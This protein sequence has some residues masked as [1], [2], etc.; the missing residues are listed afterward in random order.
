MNTQYRKNL[1][2][3]AQA[4]KDYT[5]KTKEDIL[6][7]VGEY[8]ITTSDDNTTASTKTVPSGATRVKIKKIY[9]N[10]LKYNPSVASDTTVAFMKTLPDTVYTL[11][12]SY[13]YGNSEVSEN[14]LVLQDVVETTYNGITYKVKDGVVTLNGTCDNDNTFL[15][16]VISNYVIKAGT[17]YQYALFNNM[18]NTSIL[19][20]RLCYGVTTVEEVTDANITSENVVK[21]FTRSVSQ[22]ITRL[23]I[24][25]N[26]S[27]TFNNFIFKPMLIISST[28]PTTFVKGYDGIHNLELTGLRIDGANILNVPNIAE[29]TQD[30]ITFSVTNGELK[31]K[32]TTSVNYWTYYIQLSTPISVGT[33]LCNNYYS[34]TTASTILYFKDVSYGNDYID[35]AYAGSTNRT[36][37]IT[38]TVNYIRIYIHNSGTA[39]DFASKLLI[40]KN[41]TAPT[42][43]QPYIAPTTKTID[44]STILYNG[45]P[46]FEGNSLKAVNDV[47]DIL[48]PYKATKKLGS[49]TFTGNETITQTT[50]QSGNYR[51]LILLSNSKAPLNADT[52]PNIIFSD[53]NYSVK[54]ANQIYLGNAGVGIASTGGFIFYDSSIQ[55]ETDFK[56]YITGKTINYE[57]ATPIEVSID[58]SSTLRGI[59][60]Y[61]KGTITLQNTY[62]MD[63][64]NTI[65]YN[66]MIKENCCSKIVQTRGGNVVKT[67][68]LPTQA[69]DGY[70]AGS[71]S[72]VRDFTTNKRGTNVSKNSSLGSLNYTYDSTIYKRFYVALSNAKPVATNNDV[73]NA[74]CRVYETKSVQSIFDDLT[75]DMEMGIS[76]NTTLTIR[77]LSYDDVNTFKTAMTNEPLYYE[78]AD[79]SKTET[80]IDAVENVIEVEPNDVL[81]FYNSDDELVTIPSD[82]TYRIEVA[83]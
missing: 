26:S 42:T 44:L 45:S 2:A 19:G 23:V 53:T 51:Y 59:Q 47:K 67:I 21:S 36:M 31:M 37:N 5:D 62:N 75:K 46:L 76:N 78:L 60:G 20:I 82:L 61:S 35:F 55:T 24:R 70:S 48:T 17:T 58:W 14:L 39:V 22:E 52:T 71:V 10:T 80:D 83:R 68:N 34:G 40:T 32:G 11:D 74:L 27:T 30:G 43:Y 28:A 29:T 49:Y 66:S 18:A 72:N 65:T 33:Y 64:A 25:C 4:C 63:T 81:S 15:Q 1:K 9:G 8:S 79:A 7:Q 3:V 38:K 6:W 13:V 57:L 16:L 77:N 73:A 69:S 50:I 54:T 56:A 41:A 12:V